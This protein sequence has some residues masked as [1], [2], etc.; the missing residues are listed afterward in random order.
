[1]PHIMLLHFIFTSDTFKKWLGAPLLSCT[2][3]QSDPRTIVKLGCKMKPICLSSNKYLP[4]YY[5][6]M[7]PRNTGGNQTFKWGIKRQHQQ[8]Y[9]VFKHAFDTY[10]TV[11]LLYAALRLTGISPSIKFRPTFRYGLTWHRVLE[12]H[13]NTSDPHNVYDELSCGCKQ[14][15][16]TLQHCTCRHNRLSVFTYRQFKGKIQ[17]S[18]PNTIKH[19]W[20]ASIRVARGHKAT[21]IAYLYNALLC[22]S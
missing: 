1:M 2:I 17:T 14:W 18:S 5:A 12:R 15:W 13:L 19:I 20:T 7:Y 21:L 6:F 22:V 10:S 16:W 11:G 9:F 8:I 4:P 3:I